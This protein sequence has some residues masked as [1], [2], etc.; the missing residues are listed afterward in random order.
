VVLRNSLIRIKSGL[1]ILEVI[2]FA[3]SNEACTHHVQIDCYLFTKSSSSRRSFFDRTTPVKLCSVVCIL[4]A[5]LRHQFLGLIQKVV[6]IKIHFV[7]E[8][9]KQLLDVRCCLLS[10]VLNMYRLID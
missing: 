4:I 5:C 9:E 1:K 2:F 6:H 10:F 7:N 3:V 8:L